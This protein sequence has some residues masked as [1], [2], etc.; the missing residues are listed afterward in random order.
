M[1]KWQRTLEA[2]TAS[3][4]DGEGFYMLYPSKYNSTQLLNKLGHF[5]DMLLYCGFNFKRASHTDCLVTIDIAYLDWLIYI[6]KSEK[7]NIEGAKTLRENTDH[8]HWLL[9]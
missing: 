5:E 7:S 3:M 6:K 1:K 8:R 2:L 4:L 9:L